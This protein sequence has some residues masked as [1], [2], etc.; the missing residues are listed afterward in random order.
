MFPPGRSGQ[1]TSTL[2]ISTSAAILWIIYASP[3]W[4]PL[5]WFHL[6]VVFCMFLMIHPFYPELFW[7]YYIKH[8]READPEGWPSINFC[9]G[10][11]LQIIIIHTKSLSISLIMQLPWRALVSVFLSLTYF[12]YNFSFDS[13]CSYPS[14]ILSKSNSIL[15]LFYPNDI[16]ISQLISI[17]INIADIIDS[18]R[19]Y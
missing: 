11:K 10:G 5:L 2:I 13:A 6:R 3:P 19:T 15:W 7:W 9:V 4:D 1:I 17:P 12:S 14:R 8:I 18:I 16:N